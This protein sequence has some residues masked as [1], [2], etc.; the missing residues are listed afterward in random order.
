MHHKQFFISLVLLNILFLFINCSLMNSSKLVETI[1]IDKSSISIGIEEKV[2]LTQIISPFDASDTSVTWVSSDSTTASVSST[3]MV[4]GLKAGNARI[5]VTTSDGGHSASCEVV[6]KLKILFLGNSITKHGPAPDLGW[7]GDWGMAA[8]SEDKDYVHVLIEKLLQSNANIEYKVQNIASWERSFS[9][10][11]STFT[12]IMDFDPNI[13]VIRLGENVDV[14]YAKANNYQ[15]SLEILIDYYK[16]DYSEVYITNCF[17]PNTYKDNVQK[18]VALVNNYNFVEIDS[19]STDDTNYAYLD[20][21]NSGVAYH[22]SD[23]GMQNIAYILYYA[24]TAGK[25]F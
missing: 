20:F 5:T 14:T 15:N 3:G 16:T 6:V 11:L 1:T 21:E 22:P 7:Y 9:F 4:T 2:Q 12:E 10:D 17:W 8:T 13:L 23:Y 25:Y 18:T 19:L 24:I